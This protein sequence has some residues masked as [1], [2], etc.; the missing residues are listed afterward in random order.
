M[1]KSYASG[2]PKAVHM[3]FEHSLSLDRLAGEATNN[4]NKT[5]FL[6]LSTCSRN[7]IHVLPYV[8]FGNPIIVSLPDLC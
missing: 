1:F 2:E 7:A 4:L 5:R 3:H 8:L 6:P